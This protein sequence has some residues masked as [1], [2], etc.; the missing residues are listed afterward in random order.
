M[1][2]AYIKFNGGIWSEQLKGRYDLGNYK[3]AARTC[4]NF[5]PTR[6]G[7]VEK[8]AGTQHLGYARAGTTQCVLFPF[9]YS[10]DTKFILEVGVGYIRFWSNGQQVKVG[11]SPYEVFTSYDFDEIYEIQ[12]QAVND[13]I[14]MVHPNHAPATLTRFA[15]DNWV[16]T[17]AAIS[18]PYV[19]PDVDPFTVTLTPSATAGAISI[20]ASAPA[21]TGDHLGS[22]IKMAYAQ[23]S[24]II[25][26]YDEQI[27]TGGYNPAANYNVGD[28]V[29]DTVAVG[30][31][32]RLNHYTCRVAYTGGTLGSTTPSSDYF[33][34]GIQVTQLYTTGAWSLKTTGTWNGVWEI[35][36]SVAPFTN[37]ITAKV[38]SSANDANFL[39]EDDEDGVPTVVRIVGVSANSGGWQNTN[40]TL[41]N[42]DTELF[43]YATITGVANTQLAHATVAGTLP[44]TTPTVSWQEN[45]F[46]KNQGYPRAVSVLDNRLVF[47]GTKKKPLG[48][49]YSGL[50]DYSNFLSVN[51]QADSPF[52]VETVAED[53]SPVQWITAQRELFVGTASAEGTLSGRKQDEAQS[54]ENL[55]VVRWTD[56]IGSAQRPALQ[57]RNGLLIMQRGRTVLN[58]LSYS[59]ENDGYTGEEVTLLC[60]HLFSSRIQ[61]MA[62]I[63]EPYSGA[64]TVQEDGT[65]CHMVYEPKLEV[66]GWSKYTTQG[67]EFES[68]AVLPSSGAEVSDEDEVWCVVKRTINGV[69]R[70]HIEQ[71]RV[72]N[73]NK[74][75]ANNADNVWYLD[76]ALKFTGSG[77]T[78]I[79]GLGHLEGETVCVLADGIKGSYIVSGNQITLSVPADTVIVGLPVTSEF[80]PF[81]LEVQFKGG[82]TYGKRKQ[83]YDSKLM[84]WRS[85]GG[86][87]AHDGQDYQ[88]LIYHTAGETMDESVPLKD[89]WIEVFHESSYARQKY[90]RIK[91][92]EPYPFTLQAVIQSFTVS[93]S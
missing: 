52:F 36:K 49:F 19:D 17:Q 1:D 14:Y 90:W 80:E 16:F 85:L 50:N 22:I 92:D 82:D 62:H 69:T 26:F 66:T 67:G 5:I 70:R 37:Y 41:T 7:Q 38:L 33:D 89:G 11:G 51:T 45:A 77:L 18:Q 60:P 23:D 86:S 63:R 83:L 93:K 65:M 73:T 68:V 9:Q 87:I 21:F 3:S 91:H 48:F 13:V 88:D 44:A 40:N 32:A 42:I 43:G 79:T 72:G 57:L 8:R 28:T 74:Q 10:V 58:M 47:A 56:S 15:D 46:S 29:Y 24:Q 64:F 31:P 78:T 30:T 59:L 12:I 55:P 27:A 39:V 53:Q 54:A 6:Y 75:E 2:S 81:D 4:E 71:F 35:Q 84:V 20:T 25:N 76:A 61:Q 34:Q